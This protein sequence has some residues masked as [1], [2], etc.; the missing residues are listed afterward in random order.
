MSHE[1][2]GGKI[3]LTYEWSIQNIDTEESTL[4]SPRLSSHYR[5][6]N[7]TSEHAIVDGDLHEFHV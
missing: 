7:W 3:E 4:Q 1:S 5:A 2:H 6:M